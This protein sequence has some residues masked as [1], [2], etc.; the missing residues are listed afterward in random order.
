MGATA[1]EGFGRRSRSR[2]KAGRLICFWDDTGLCCWVSVHRCPDASMLF[3]WDLLSSAPG[4]SWT[5]AASWQQ[6]L[7]LHGM[8]VSVFL[9][10][11]LLMALQGGQKASC[12]AAGRWQGK[13]V[14]WWETHPFGSCVVSSYP[15]S[16]LHSEV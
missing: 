10:E 3:P 11:L 13:A 15:P 12:V 6:M 8:R 2:I 9:Q 4:R 1:L 14:K 7:W 16:Q 5:D